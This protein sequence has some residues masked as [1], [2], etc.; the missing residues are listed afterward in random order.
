MPRLITLGIL[1]DIHFASAAEQARGEDYEFEC[2]LNPLHRALLKFYRRFIWLRHPLHQNHLL[3]AF[4][5]RIGPADFVVANG[6]YSSNTAFVGLSDDAAFESA[7]QCL[8]QLRERFCQ[9]FRATFGDHELGK[10]SLVGARGGMRIASYVRAQEEL[11]LEPLWR[12]DLGRYVLVGVTS[13]VVALPV[14]ESD[15]LPGERPLWE[16]ARAEHLTRIRE[17]FAALEPKQR[18]L[19]F[20]H[21]PTALPYLWREQA[22][23]LRIDQIDQTIIGHLHSSLIFWKSRVLA[24]MPAIGFAGPAVKRMTGALREARRWKPFKV[25]LCPSLAGIE[26]LKDGGYL[27]AELDPDA[28]RPVRFRRH[29]IPR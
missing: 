11:S 24:G 21:D 16:Q 12:V 19:L 26:L 10:L 9:N 6:D 25:R 4:L 29:P 14:F 18:V 8:T 2:R 13:S 17:T 1:S 7:R 5:E 27:T 3:D 28:Q 20:C 15:L 23:R 22:V